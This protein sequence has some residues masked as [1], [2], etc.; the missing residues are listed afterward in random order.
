MDLKRKKVV[1]AGAE[2]FM[3]S[4]LVEWLL[5]KKCEVKK[6]HLNLYKPGIYNV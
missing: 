2:G 4:H 6:R 3:G 1:V 5:R